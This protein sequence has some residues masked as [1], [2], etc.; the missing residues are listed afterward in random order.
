[1]K[2][3]TVVSPGAVVATRAS[4]SFADFV[5]LTKPRLNFLVVAS[6]AAGY[7][8]GAAG[9]IDGWRMAE[10]VAG[11]ALVAG[12]AAGLNQV[13]ERDTDALMRRTRRRP[14]PDGRVGTLDAA[15]FG[16]A[17]AFAG[18]VLLGTRS[19]ALAASLAAATLIVYLVVYTPMKR[20]TSLATLVGA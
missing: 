12:G 10:A 15:L 7:F 1:M 13:Y 5:N 9:A 8:L 16:L 17:L 6:S 14:L 19:N 2:D 11:T 4:N 18:L 20:R 3:A